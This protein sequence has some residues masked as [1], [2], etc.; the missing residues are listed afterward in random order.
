MERG[1]RM[2]EQMNINNFHELLTSDLDKGSL[3]DVLRGLTEIKD[4]SDF[5]LKGGPQPLGTW[6]GWRW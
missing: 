6:A 5:A 3:I 2:N 1:V 4:P